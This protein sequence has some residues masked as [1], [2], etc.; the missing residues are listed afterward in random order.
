MGS[1]QFA[2]LK[3]QMRG[4]NML[5]VKGHSIVIPTAEVNEDLIRRGDVGVIS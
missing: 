4:A 2:P 3:G 1:V 5:K